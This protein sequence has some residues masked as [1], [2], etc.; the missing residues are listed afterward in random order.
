[1]N[2]VIRVFIYLEKKITF[3]S[4]VKADECDLKVDKTS[5]KRES[6]F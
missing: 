1:M 4:I 3:K 2:C 5:S 6:V